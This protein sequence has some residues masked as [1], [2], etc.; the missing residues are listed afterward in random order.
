MGIH[1]PKKNIE[2]HGKNIGMYG[3]LRNT[4]VCLKWGLAGVKNFGE[5]PYFLEKACLA[6]TR[7]SP[8]LSKKISS[9]FKQTSVY[10]FDMG[11]NVKDHW[12]F[13]KMSLNRGKKSDRPLKPICE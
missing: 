8:F 10:N 7:N 12:A 1:G 3:P 6:N 5:S 4:L 13:N 9:H 11:S 2:R